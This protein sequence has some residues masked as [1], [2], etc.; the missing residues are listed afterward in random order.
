MAQTLS[1]GAEARRLS[2]SCRAQGL[3]RHAPL[4]GLLGPV[5]T[6]VD[7]RHTARHGT[8]PWSLEHP[9]IMRGT[10]LTA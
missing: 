1:H 2:S 8:T 3:H 7:L 6:L 5:A 9:P 4:R 10:V